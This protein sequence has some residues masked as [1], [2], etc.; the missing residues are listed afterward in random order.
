MA[1]ATSSYIFLG[2]ICLYSNVFTSIGK[3]QTILSY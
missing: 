3:T 1:S 2:L